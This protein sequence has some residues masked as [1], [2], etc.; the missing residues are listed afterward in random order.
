MCP[1]DATNA[2]FVMGSI[3][4]VMSRR[5]TPPQYVEGHNISVTRLRYLA[6]HNALDSWPIRVRLA[7][8]NYKL[9]KNQRVSER[10]GIEEQQ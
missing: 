10:R 7:S 2:S 3:V 5:E 4:L 9:C 8:Q 1:L 6:N